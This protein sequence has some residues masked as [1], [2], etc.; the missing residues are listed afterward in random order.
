[1]SD[2][3]SHLLPADPQHADRLGRAG[4]HHDPRNRQWRALD[5]PPRT[6]TGSRPWHSVFVADQLG[7]SCTA[8]AAVGLLETQ[9]HTVPHRSHRIGYDTEQERF[10]LYREAQKV[11]PWQGENYEGSSGDAPLR[12]LRDRGV[13]RE[14][15]WLFGLVEVR[16]YLQTR[17][18]V[19]VGT[20]WLES[21]MQARRGRLE[22]IPESG[23][24]GG[25]QWRI[26]GYNPSRF[27]YRMVN[28]WGRGW[29][30]GGRAWVNET[31]LEWLLAQQGDAVTVV[32]R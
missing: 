24:V 25:H 14:W 28:S 16:E 5:I 26:V 2:G 6:A 32:P 9:P 18:P 4:V 1:M 13:I 19:S 29:G 31:D 17:G 3:D 12:V 8:A 27:L 22:V 30:E 7:P 15:R 23:A 10:A 21:M 11:D 20:V